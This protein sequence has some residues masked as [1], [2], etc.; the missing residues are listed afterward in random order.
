MKT[1]GLLNGGG[2]GVCFTQSGPGSR[3][4]IQPCLKLSS[5]MLQSG[6]RHSPLSSPP[7]APMPSRTFTCQQRANTPMQLH[8]ALVRRL[9]WWAVISN[10]K[11]CFK[12]VQMVEI[13]LSIRRN[14][15]RAEWPWDMPGRMVLGGE[16]SGKRD[17]GW[18]GVSW[19]VSSLVKEA[20]PWPAAIAIMAVCSH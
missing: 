5:S 6:S 18:G 15:P 1:S 3:Y 20:F 16:L 19:N 9:P 12:N 7:L 4:G 10:R 13:I 2:G 14:L 8:I 11:K 17:G